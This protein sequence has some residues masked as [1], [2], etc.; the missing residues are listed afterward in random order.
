MNGIFLF[1]HSKSSSFQ[2]IAHGEEC[3]YTV[4]Y[5]LQ[6]I[7]EFLFFL[8]VIGRRFYWCSCGHWRS[9]ICW[10][11][12]FAMG[13][14]IGNF[15]R[16]IIFRSITIRRIHHVF[17]SLIRNIYWFLWLPFSKGPSVAVKSHSVNILILCR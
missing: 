14:C 7:F 2:S 5:V 17:T 9:C 16:R 1:G 10:C 4:N 12:R 6:Q 15:Y 3:V 11:L 8:T 13:V